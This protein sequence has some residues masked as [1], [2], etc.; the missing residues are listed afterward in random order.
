MSRLRILAERKG[1]EYPI[2]Q[3]EPASGENSRMQDMIDKGLLGRCATCEHPCVTFAPGI[4]GFRPNSIFK[5][6]HRGPGNSQENLKTVEIYE[7]PLMRQ[8]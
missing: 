3:R 7:N 5:R 8:M 1:F 2:P 6:T 4:S